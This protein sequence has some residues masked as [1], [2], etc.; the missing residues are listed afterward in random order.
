MKEFQKFI[1]KGNVVEIAVGLIMATYFGAI[2]KSLVNDVI[3]PPIG[4]LLGGVDFSTMKVVLQEASADGATAEVA[5][6]YGIFFNTVLTFIIVAFAVFMIVK[7][8]NRMKERWEKKE[9]AAP[10][11]PPKP[12]KEELLLT[13]IRDLLKK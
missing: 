10:A 4:L 8:Y 1:S 9:E 5:I 13:E 3:M 11:A 12:T 2:A 6:N 7:S